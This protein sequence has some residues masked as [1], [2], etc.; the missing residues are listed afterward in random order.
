MFFFTT[1][2]ADWFH[3]ALRRVVG[4][5]RRPSVS[6]ALNAALRAIVLLFHTPRA[7]GYFA[8]PFVFSCLGLS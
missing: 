5:S 1:R 4:F 2:R 7:G 8:F 6:G 3:G